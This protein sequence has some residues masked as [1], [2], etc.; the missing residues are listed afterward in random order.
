MTLW[1]RGTECFLDEQDPL[2][3]GPLRENDISKVST[4]GAELVEGFEWDT[5]D[6]T[7]DSQVGSFYFSISSGCPSGAN[8]CCRSKRYMSFSQITTSR[9]MR[10]C[11][12]ST[13]RRLF[14]TGL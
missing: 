2:P 10:L 4:K 14:S 3:D 6:L 13:T 1:V 8:E 7:N 9:T 5:I 12:V 11:F